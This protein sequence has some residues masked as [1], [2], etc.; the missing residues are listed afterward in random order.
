MLK[1]KDTMRSW[2][3]SHQV[4]D[5]KRRYPRESYKNRGHKELKH[6]EV[7]YHADKACSK[8]KLMSANWSEPSQS[9]M[10]WGDTANFSVVL[11]QWDVQQSHVC[12]V[13]TSS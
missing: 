6:S 9:A 4:P 13:C 7:K 2:A 10:N 3:I 5:H 11:R 12:D 8:H 1:K